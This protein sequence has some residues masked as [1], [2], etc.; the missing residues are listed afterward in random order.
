MEVDAD[1]EVIP[2]DVHQKQVVERLLLNRVEEEVGGE[3]T[4]E[5]FES[6]ANLVS[7]HLN[8]VE[9]SLSVPEFVFIVNK[10]LRIESFHLPKVV[11]DV[12]F[13]YF[14]RPVVDQGDGVLLTSDV[15]HQFVP[16]S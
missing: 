3:E 14:E 13:A 16:E 10:K 7:L 6:R 1:L 12:E 15:G 11:A 8:R 4:P 5:I 2:N 9:V